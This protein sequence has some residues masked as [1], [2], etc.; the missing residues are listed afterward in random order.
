MAINNGGESERKRNSN[1]KRR[2]VKIIVSMGEIIG[3]SS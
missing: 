3:E 1:E 2:N